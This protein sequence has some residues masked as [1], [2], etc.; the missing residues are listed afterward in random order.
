MD[1]LEDSDSDNSETRDVKLVGT[2]LHSI[3]MCDE[4]GNDGDQATIDIVLENWKSDWRKDIE[5]FNGP[6]PQ[7]MAVVHLAYGNEPSL[8]WHYS[9]AAILVDVPTFEKRK[10]MK[11]S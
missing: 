5:W 8:K 7:E 1:D 10:S 3:Q 9:S 2:D 11:L 6:G 4:G